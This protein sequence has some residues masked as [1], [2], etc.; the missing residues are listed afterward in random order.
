MYVD[1]YSE[2]QTKGNKYKSEIIFFPNKLN[3]LA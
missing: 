2:F 3:P 1:Y